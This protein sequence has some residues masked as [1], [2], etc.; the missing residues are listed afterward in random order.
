MRAWLFK[1]VWVKDIEEYNKKVKPKDR[2]NHVVFIIDE[3]ADLRLWEFWKEIEQILEKISNVWRSA[4]IHL[5]LASQRFD[6]KVLSWRLKNNIPTRIS[7]RTWSEVDSRVL[8]DVWWAEK[9]LGKWDM[10][11]KNSADIQRLQ[12]FYI[13]N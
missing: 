8:L 10:L 11:Y 1:T 6:T 7:L 5:V 2:I 12:A 13:P 4:W 3:M 9:L